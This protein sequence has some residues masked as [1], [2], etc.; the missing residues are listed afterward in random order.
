MQKHYFFILLIFNGYRSVSQD[1]GGITRIRD[2]SYT[3]GNEYIKQIKAYPFI[4]IVTDTA[5]AT[6]R[7][8]KNITYCRIKNRTLKLDIFRPDEKERAKRRT[9]IFIHG[10][11]WR[12]GDR[13][14]HHPLMQRLAAMGY[15]CIAPEYRLSTEILFPAAVHDIKT[16]IRWARKNAAKYNVDRSRIIVAGHS[17]GGELAAFIGATNNKK[18][19]EGN[20]QHRGVSSAANAVIDI[21]GILSFVHPESGEG[22]DSKRKSA[23]TLWFGYPKHINTELWKQASPLTHAGPHCPPF[24]FINSPVERMHAGRND[25]IKMM[26]AHNIYVEI[27]TYNNAPHTFCFFHPWFHPMIADIDSFIRKIFP[28]K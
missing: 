21:D 2:T 19:F 4:R 7:G 12:S 13:S 14:M 5:D 28:E 6:I 17:A 11:G 18:E 22:D 8:E 26:S 25:F 3:V 16:V 15:V 20:G 24:L 23:A 10:G 1:T 27:K 9:I